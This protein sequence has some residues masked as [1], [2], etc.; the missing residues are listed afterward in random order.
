MSLEKQS[1]RARLDLFLLFSFFFVGLS[2]II[3]LLI[4]ADLYLSNTDKQQLQQQ[5]TE[6]KLKI[7]NNFNSLKIDFRPSQMKAKHL[8]SSTTIVPSTSTSTTTIK[9]T[10]TLKKFTNWSHCGQTFSQPSIDPSQLVKRR[11]KRIIGGEDAIE[12]SWPF[13]VSI[14]IKIKGQTKHHCGGTLFTDQVHHYGSTFINHL[15][16]RFQG[17]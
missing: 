7:N 13:L 1:R 9:Q 11:T 12:H 8:H 4:L 5:P 16:F 14:R 15:S 10:T 3:S 2:A 17:N 6:S